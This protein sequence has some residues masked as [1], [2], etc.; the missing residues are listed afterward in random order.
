MRCSHSAMTAPIILAL[1]GVGS[2][3]WLLL[4]ALFAGLTS[5]VSAA[6]TMVRRT[7]MADGLQRAGMLHLPA[8]A[9]R[10]PVPLVFA[11]HGH[12]GSMRQAARSF[13]LQS[14]WPDAAFV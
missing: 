13:N 4:A 14:L 6:E 1:K 7:W 2:R 9:T 12:G 3:R 8:S 10:Q 11:F 5:V